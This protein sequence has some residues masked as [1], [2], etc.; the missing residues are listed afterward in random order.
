MAGRTYSAA[1]IA[2]DTDKD[3]AGFQGTPFSGTFDGRGHVI[4]HLTI[5]SDIYYDYLGLF[6]MIAPGGRIDNLHLPDVD[7]AGGRGTSTYIGA[8]AG[9][10]GG[11]LTDCS[12]TGIVEGGRGDGLVGFNSGSLIECQADVTRI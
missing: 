2:P 9:Y 7:L 4:R 10:N 5:R 11:T 3:K 8:L 1:L 6:G 12:A